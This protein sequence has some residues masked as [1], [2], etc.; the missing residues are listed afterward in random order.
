VVAATARERGVG[1]GRWSSY[2]NDGE[3]PGWR[4]EGK[5]RVLE[6]SARKKKRGGVSVRTSKLSTNA[7][8]SGA[9]SSVKG[10]QVAKRGEK[11]KLSSSSSFPVPL[12]FLPI[13]TAKLA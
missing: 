11:P 2:R 13:P 6:R 8:G 1:V 3:V 12:R 10:E 9:E 7:H 4:G 5:G